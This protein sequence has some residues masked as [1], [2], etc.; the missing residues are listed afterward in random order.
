MKIAA[1]AN[2]GTLEDLI[3]EKFEQSTH[4]LI[5]EMDDYSLEVYPRDNSFG[6]PESAMVRVIIEKDCEAVI[7]GSI[8]QPSFD[9]L[10]EMQVTRYNGAGHTVR[11]ALTLMEKYRLDFIRSFEGEP[12]DFHMLR[13]HHSCDCSDHD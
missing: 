5:V 11:E 12:A 6:S 1:A 10:V 8:R 2:G 4:L 9:A 13:H 7:T 3:A